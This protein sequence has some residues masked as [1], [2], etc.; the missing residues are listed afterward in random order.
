MKYIKS[1]WSFNKYISVTCPCSFIREFTVHM[2]PKKAGYPVRVLKPKHELDNRKT[3]NFR[4][5][6]RTHKPDFFGY[7]FFFLLN[8]LMFISANNKK[9]LSLNYCFIP[10]S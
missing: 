10:K 1:P 9:F 7:E 2:H 6:T 5:Q 3:R 8:I 4:V